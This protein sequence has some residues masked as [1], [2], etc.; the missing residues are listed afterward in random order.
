MPIDR[1]NSFNRKGCPA[2]TAALTQVSSGTRPGGDCVNLGDFCS[3]DCGWAPEATPSVYAVL[4]SS[5]GRV[6][7]HLDTSAAQVG[8]QSFVLLAA[9]QCILR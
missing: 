2:S 1:L 8:A 4:G 7:V 3:V 6:E 5:S 9:E